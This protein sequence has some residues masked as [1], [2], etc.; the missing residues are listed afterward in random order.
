MELTVH[1][2]PDGTSVKEVERLAEAA[3]T[4]LYSTMDL[5]RALCAERRQTLEFTTLAETVPVTETLTAR[6]V[7]H[8]DGQVCL[9]A[10]ERV[11]ATVKRD[12]A[13]AEGE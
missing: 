12:G 10:G 4:R 6:A 9:R 1:E 13:F 2:V 7:L 5:I 8:S 3:A 11:L